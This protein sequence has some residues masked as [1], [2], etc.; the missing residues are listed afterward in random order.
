MSTQASERCECHPGRIWKDKFGDCSV[1]K[2][3]IRKTIPTLPTQGEK[4]NGINKFT[5]YDIKILSSE[6]KIE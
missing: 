4:I 1:C 6:E 5:K 3:P 2:K